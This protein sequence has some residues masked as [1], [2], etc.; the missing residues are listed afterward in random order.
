MLVHLNLPCE[1][2]VRSFDGSGKVEPAC[3]WRNLVK[4]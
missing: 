1:L 2:D 4:C 3:S